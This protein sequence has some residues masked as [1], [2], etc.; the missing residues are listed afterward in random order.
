M[1]G[2]AIIWGFLFLLTALL[3]AMELIN[4]SI[5]LR[6]WVCV[7]LIM[8]LIALPIFTI[9]NFNR[10]VQFYNAYV[11]F[12]NRINSNLTK[13][14][15]Y[16]VLDR[17]INYNYQLYLYQEKLHKWGIFSTVYRGFKDLKP[18]ELSSFDMENYR[19]WQ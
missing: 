15:E 1:L 11:M 16:M 17:A 12:Q 14:Q 9:G 8:I 6:F 13:D 3:T 2:W 5:E 18:I 4:G 19:F 10:S 7:L